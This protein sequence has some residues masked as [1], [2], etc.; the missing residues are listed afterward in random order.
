M[1][2]D[3]RGCKNIKTYIIDLHNKDV[4]AGPWSQS[5]VEHRAN[6]MIAAPYPF[7]GIIVVGDC[8]ITFISGSGLMNS[9]AMAECEMRAYGLID[10]DASACRYL[11]GDAS[12]NLF[13]LVIHRSQNVVGGLTLDPIGV[14]SI[15]RNLCYLNNGIVFVASALGDSQLIKLTELCDEE[16][17][18][19]R[20]IDI[21]PNVGPIVDMCVTATERQ[22]QSVAVTC[23]GASKDGTLRVIR[24]GISIEEQVH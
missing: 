20:V 6:F 8:T 21:Y 2:E 7:D 5:N 23:S 9:I 19:V 24:S 15:P 1:Y 22:G 18:H 12:G 14:T 17:S 11:L 16:G 3:G 10:H 4:T 13:V